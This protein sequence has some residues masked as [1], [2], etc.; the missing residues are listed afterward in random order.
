MKR[1][2]AIELRNH[3]FKRVP[4]HL[5]TIEKLPGCREGTETAGAAPATKLRDGDNGDNVDKLP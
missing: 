1:Q 4:E 5:W 2:I 3:P